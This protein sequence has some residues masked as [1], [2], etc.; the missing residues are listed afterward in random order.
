MLLVQ[1]TGEISVPRLTVGES[2]VIC[3][4]S[5]SASVEVVTVDLVS[6]TRDGSEILEVAV[7]GIGEV[8]FIV[9]GVDDK[10]V[11][12]VEL[13]TKVVVEEN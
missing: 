5:N 6:Q 9:S 1:Y 7:E 12:G 8:E 11:K 10:V 2:K 13:S 4:N 3:N